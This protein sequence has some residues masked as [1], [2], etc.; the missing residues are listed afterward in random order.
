MPGFS[1]QKGP[2]GK[3]VTT[4]DGPAY[5][6]N[7][8][9]KSP[10]ASTAPA[11]AAA[12][13]RF[14][15]DGRVV[16][17]GLTEILSTAMPGIGG[18]VPMGFGAAKGI[19]TLMQT[20]DPT[21][22]WK[23]G[24]AETAAILE[25]SNQ[26]G[27]G[28]GQTMARTQY[29]ATR[30]LFQS[31]FGNLPAAKTR[32]PGQADSPLFGVI[33]PLPK[34]KSTG[35]VEDMATNILQTGQGIAA[36]A[37]LLRGGAALVAP[38]VGAVPGGTAVLSGLAA[39]GRLPATLR[40][41]AAATEGVGGVSGALNAAANIARV[42]QIATQG[43]LVGGIANYAAI[44]P[45]EK[46][47]ADQ[48]L[49]WAKGSNWL[50]LQEY[51]FSKPGDTEADARWKNAV[52]NL[53]IDASVNVGLHAL[54]IA[55]KVAISRVL[56][57]EF[58]QG[59][60]DWWAKQ[61]NQA[62][63]RPQPGT[64]AGQQ[65][66]DVTAQP[67][68]EPVAA[69]APAAAAPAP[70]AA[71][72]A[73]TAPAPSVVPVPPTP[74]QQARIDIAQQGYNTAKA[75]LDAIGPEPPKPSTEKVRFGPNGIAGADPAAVA[76]WKAETR[77]YQSWSRKYLKLKKEE[78]SA[79]NL[80]FD[81]K[82]ETQIVTPSKDFWPWND[83]APTPAAPTAADVNRAVDNA[84][85]KLAHLSGTVPTEMGPV[86]PET[87]GSWRPSFNQVQE[88]SVSDLSTDPQ[89]L[90]Y[91][92]AG[93]LV[94]GGVTGTLKDVNVYNPL[95]A[96]PISV[97]TDPV[98][99]K[100]YVVNGHNQ[101]D[102]AKRAGSERVLTW[103]IQASTAE[104]A[105][106]IGAIENMAA[107]QGTAL[108]AAK[109]IRD[110]GITGEE[111]KTRGVDL[112][113]PI[114][115]DAM[116][117]VQLP[118][119][120]FNKVVAGKLDLAK[121]I[122]LGN[123]ALT[124]EVPAVGTGAITPE[125]LPPGEMPVAPAAAPA[126]PV[127]QA[128][129]AAPANLTVTPLTGQPLE[130]VVPQVVTQEIQIPPGASRPLPPGSPRIDTVSQSIAKWLGTSQDEARNMLLAK[131]EVLDVTKVP[132]IDL[133]KAL[134]DAAMGR[135]SPETQAITRAYQQF[136][137]P[138]SRQ[139]QEEMLS[140]VNRVDGAMPD[141]LPES[142]R[143][144]PEIAAAVKEAMMDTVR[145]IAG[146]DIAFIFEEGMAKKPGT[147][148]HGTQGQVRRTLG[149]Y[150]VNS[151]GIIEDGDPIQEIVQFNEMG[152]LR[153]EGQSMIDWTQQNLA[154]AAHEAFH[155]IQNRYLSSKQLDVLDNVF[156]RIR[157]YKMTEKN[158]QKAAER[159]ATG[160]Q[161]QM[162][163][164][165]QPQAFEG[166]D[167]ARREGVSPALV[168]LG[169]NKEDVEMFKEVAADRNSPAARRLAAKFGELIFS[170]VKILDNLAN[171][172]E[173]L[174]NTFRGRGWTSIRDI[175]SQA[176]AG[177]LKVSG[178]AR[179]NV[180]D[181]YQ[182]AGDFKNATDEGNKEWGRR[183]RALLKQ[184]SPYETLR[185]VGES[186]GLFSELASE[187]GPPRTPP[188]PPMPDGPGNE[189]W[190]TRFA[191]VL[192]ENEA[193]L[194]S[195]D[196]TMEELY[197]L[198]RM[199]KTESP[200]GSQ[201]YTTKSQELI[202]GY[203]AMSQV[204]PD[205]PTATGY[206][207]FNGPEIV[208]K[209]QAWFDSHGWDGKAIM[210]GISSLQQGFRGHEMGALN[211]A[212]SYADMLQKE[213]Q[214]QAAQWLNS[215]GSGTVNKS[216]R[217][218]ALI[219]AAD[220]ARRIHLAIANV[221]RPWGQAGAEMQ[222]PRDYQVSANVIETPAGVELPPSMIQQQISQELAQG[223]ANPNAVFEEITD[224]LDPELTHAAKGGEITPQAE[225]AA[226]AL[227]EF[228]NSGGVDPTIRTG[229]W[230]DLANVSSA[231]PGIK[232]GVVGA[233][234]DNPLTMLRVNNLLSSG[235]TSNVNFIN[236]LF[237][238]ARFSVAHGVGALVER[239]LDRALYSATMFSTAFANIPNA[240]RLA[241]H[242]IKAGKPL[243]NLRSSVV[244]N[245]QKMAAQDA[246]G[247]LLPDDPNAKT[248]WTLTTMNLGEQFAKTPTGQA[249][250][251]LWGT[252]GTGAS[253]VIVGLDTFNATLAGHAFEHFNHL[254]RGMELAVENKLQK[255]TPEA[256]AYATNYAK[257]RVKASLQDAI[258]NGKTIADAVMT[259][260]DAQKF[261]D[262]VNFTEDL[263]VKMEPRTL[264][265]GMRLGESRGLKG[266]ELTK[267][268]QEYVNTANWEHKVATMGHDRLGKVANV[269]GEL[270]NMSTNVPLVGP[271]F[272]YLQ[273]FLRV[274]GNMFKEAFRSTPG[275]NLFVD[276]FYRDIM[277]EN[278]AM[279]QRA[280]GEWLLGGA[281]IGTAI[282]A[283]VMGQVR[284]N[285]NG[286]TDPIARENWL[287]DRKMPNSI[288][289]WD[290]SIKGWGPAISMRAF[291]PYSTLLSAIGD[292]NDVAAGLT[293]EQRTRLGSA[294]ALDVLRMQALGLLNK[295]YFQG[296]NEL[297]QA[298]FD[299][300]KVM[301]GPSSRNSMTRLL[302][303]VVASM[304][305]WSSAMRSARRQV[306]PIA[307]SVDPAE[308][309]NFAM[310][311]FKETM[312]EIR[313]QTPGLSFALA[314][315]RD[316]SLP[317]APYMTVPQIL[318]SEVVR[319]NPFLVGSMQFTPF[320]IM[321]VSDG[322]TDPVQRE[323]STLYGKGT[324]FSGP[325]AADF[326]PEL[327]LTP[328]EL[329]EYQLAF[330]TAR[331]A[332]G[333]TWY[334]RMSE[335]INSPNYMALPVEAPS[336]TT[337]SERAA[338]I[339]IQ[340]D[341]FK[342]LAKEEYKLTTEK[343]RQITAEQLRAEQR[344]QEVLFGRQYGTSN[345]PQP[346]GAE[347]FV[348][349]MNP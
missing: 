303:R 46:T 90:Q 128:A 104:E 74:Q 266:D 45:E 237:N 145:R 130:T 331:D 30:N 51:I 282:A 218:T 220:N 59:V 138:S 258:I 166:F 35:P 313:N 349:E 286:P 3:Y 320:S 163:I 274:P 192:A 242:A 52:F 131:N 210:A 323:M 91:K 317:G 247:N 309:G 269:P 305:P 41:M 109:V 287:K 171:F 151:V 234:G 123:K 275:L 69:P 195:G 5:Q 56:K 231:K 240:L 117:L 212:M 27:I 322:P 152:W 271:I 85:T 250:N 44:T 160:A 147:R 113:A 232:A 173:K 324:A 66:V 207:I 211:R 127:A 273:P 73:P 189:N 34:A 55:A 119:Q 348:R 246:Q 196:I 23:A 276:S 65:T 253:R 314:G 94:E 293:T 223:D 243:F 260:K 162:P 227:A 98:D 149:N 346:G 244:E 24:T 1:F 50:P 187:A 325:R 193:A 144:D 301:T 300:S 332:E 43:S 337:V 116:A 311:F 135:T 302:E 230:Q 110:M 26:P 281:V 245:Y 304:Q 7:E 79:S 264:A 197:V 328:T 105:R 83:A 292:Y 341:K 194:K 18:M 312:D 48:W 226:D 288:Q 327:R 126:A 101:L 165:L 168:I 254:P 143:V 342:K 183:V 42:G 111:L 318:G 62:D 96:K 154:T 102:L 219:S 88:R 180:Y 315:R 114:T 142:M 167:Q 107:G 61:Q 256:F 201:V 241:G 206:P 13:A 299:P 100:L 129:P 134:D 308:T 40:T 262:A 92:E 36:T 49:G 235:E 338:R 316:W 261:M 106:A 15:D 263:R 80:L 137:G 75:K 112:N 345:A 68:A 199:Q 67:V 270:L 343:G 28:I 222:L 291:E 330:G 136:Y 213:A 251:W 60:G 252:V 77:A 11:P 233:T 21:K 2:D 214:I 10:G 158:I 33:P 39:A 124:P 257:A 103:E 310:D 229:V 164:E 225:A 298:A 184:G 333:F 336:S 306:D 186:E 19:Q 321:R 146:D 81:A 108:D 64:P 203:A 326:G 335:M 334:E 71:A 121:A 236:G 118:Q 178:A 95:L 319:D 268:A 272:I 279:R 157:L 159:K 139:Q 289:F 53:P 191:K 54:G 76:K 115:R 175:F 347:R 228:I 86:T 224:V 238:I 93:Q 255:Y 72:P 297:Y 8:P 58:G 185:F 133:E 97:W 239:D 122:E 82:K 170:A 32:R 120:T 47:Q 209:N 87:R 57:T 295:T 38:V 16:Q 176:A 200:S 84:A 78:V 89:R 205:R 294:L 153:Y 29:N 132:G 296:I 290:E 204:L 156:A 198:N 277:S 278:P 169:M 125:V 285:G 267:Y 280:N 181:L 174:W 25:P 161:P 148:A 188:T 31:V 63:F 344:K 20:G 22:A 190:A 150:R 6:G 208:A 140:L 37:L 265:E 339:Q 141:E 217:L 329:S 249:L 340:I 248:G 177:E 283:T 155:I 215:I 14:R 172:A 9:L 70:A 4:F 202:P 284:S 259:S 12:L 17:R 99:G 216:E 179:G 182:V 307:R 221:T